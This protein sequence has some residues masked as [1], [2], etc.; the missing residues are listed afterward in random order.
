MVVFTVSIPAIARVCSSRGSSSKLEASAP[1][2]CL[3]SSLDGGG[4][5]LKVS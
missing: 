2:V 1:S 3:L 4:M 5:P